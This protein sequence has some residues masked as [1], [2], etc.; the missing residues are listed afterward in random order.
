MKFFFNNFNSILGNS[1]LLWIWMNFLKKLDISKKKKILL[2]L[3][4]NKKKKYFI[5]CLL[6]NK[7]IKFT[8]LN[9]FYYI[10]YAKK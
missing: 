8:N 7:I 10:I 2:N 9:G 6:F 3:I 4:K 5:K 1:S